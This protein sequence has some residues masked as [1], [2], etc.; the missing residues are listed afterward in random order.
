ME[1]GVQW[2]HHLN[3]VCASIKLEVDGTPEVADKNELARALEEF[4]Q[5]RK[6]LE[7]AMENAHVTRFK[8]SPILVAKQL[9]QDP[10]PEALL[11]YYTIE[12]YTL[13]PNPEWA[14]QERQRSESMILSR[15]KLNICSKT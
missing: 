4:L 11:T 1:T 5:H 12:R 8:P 14:T 2:Y 13:T 6:A 15:L 7:Y 10:S 3:N 9:G